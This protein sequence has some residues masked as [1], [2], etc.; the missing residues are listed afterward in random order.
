M[1]TIGSATEQL[2]RVQN[3]DFYDPPEAEGIELEF[4]LLYSGPLPAATGGEN[5]K[6]EKNA[7]RKAIHVQLAA[8]WS[9]EIVT[10]RFYAFSIKPDYRQVPSTA[11]EPERI[12]ENHKLA[13]KAN[14]IYRFVPMVGDRFALSCSLDIL[15]MRRDGPGGIVHHG[16]DIDNR[17][18]V[19]L[20]ALRMPQNSG[21]L[22]D[23][24]PG[25]GEDPF[26]C[27]M[28]DDKYI[29]ALTITTD[30]LL[31]P[32]GP[33][34]QVNDVNLVIHVKPI[35]TDPRYAPWIFW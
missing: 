25:P 3:F 18:K 27:L 32:S 12:A 4:R 31:V 14:A 17:V 5:R 21:E 29:T 28:E 34:H 19:L 26:Y 33:G 1:F 23:D 8:F 6:A 13:N 30:R 11:F 22:P 15:F 10:Q 24:P 35:V 2:P 7:I 20:D 16:G 9:Q